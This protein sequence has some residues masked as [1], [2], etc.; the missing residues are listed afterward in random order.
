MKINKITKKQIKVKKQKQQQQQNW[1]P[2]E[3]VSNR[4]AGK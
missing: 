3:V 1:N 4:C 2:E